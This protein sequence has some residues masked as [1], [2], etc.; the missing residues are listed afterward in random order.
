M[1]YGVSQTV[2]SAR[3]LGSWRTGGARATEV[4]PR[5]LSLI[6]SPWDHVLCGSHPCSFNRTGLPARSPVEAPCWR[7]KIT[8]AIVTSGFG[9]A[10]NQLPGT[11][12]KPIPTRQPI[13]DCLQGANPSEPF[14]SDIRTVKSP[15]KAAIPAPVNTEASEVKLRASPASR[16]GQSPPL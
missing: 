10:S 7:P 16:G 5:A 6:T 3:R 12:S 15:R 2:S 8:M 14:D 13:G 4:T 1:V 11:L 9:I